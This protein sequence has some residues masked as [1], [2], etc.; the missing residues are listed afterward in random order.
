[1]REAA[2]ERDATRPS[3]LLPTRPVGQTDP[4]R[5][6][7]GEGRVAVRVAEAV[8]APGDA[9][10]VAADPPARPAPPPVQFA[11]IPWTVSGPFSLNPLP[12]YA[13]RHDLDWRQ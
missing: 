5:T 3:R 8:V 13:A 10:P 11:D 9:A 6:D 4:G 12:R 1:M 7:P 2:S